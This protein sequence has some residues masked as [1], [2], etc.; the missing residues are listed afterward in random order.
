MFGHPQA[1]PIGTEPLGLTR[2]QVTQMAINSFEG[3][4]LSEAEKAAR[5]AEVRAYAGA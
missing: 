1:E 3:S 4:F 2:E 5:I